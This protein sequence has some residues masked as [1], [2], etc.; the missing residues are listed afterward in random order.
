MKASCVTDANVI[1]H[2]ITGGFHFSHCCSQRVGVLQLGETAR[3]P[4]S[5]TRRW[6][7]EGDQLPVSVRPGVGAVGWSEP[8]IGKWGWWFSGYSGRFRPVVIAP[9]YGGGVLGDRHGGSTRRG[10]ISTPSRSTTT[11]TTSILSQL[12]TP[13]L[14]PPASVPS[15]QSSPQPLLE[16]DTRSYAGRRRVLLPAADSGTTS[17]SSTPLGTMRDGESAA[18]GFRIASFSRPRTQ[19]PKLGTPDPPC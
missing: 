8:E 11:G 14:P 19:D 10:R 9:K 3:T 18:R 1:T 4:G 13:Q 17:S 16:S 2:I 15:M 6:R 5:E 7:S 12:P